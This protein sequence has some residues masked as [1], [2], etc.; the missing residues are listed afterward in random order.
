M[1]KDELRGITL[2]LFHISAQLNA[3]TDYVMKNES[4]SERDKIRKQISEEAEE[5]LRIIDTLDSMI[6]PE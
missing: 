5:K 6:I 3:L 1:G 2:Q 4:Q